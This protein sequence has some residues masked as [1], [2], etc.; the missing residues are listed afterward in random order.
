M[1]MPWGPWLVWGTLYMA[2]EREHGL[3]NGKT[4]MV[5]VLITMLP[6][7]KRWMCCS[8]KVESQLKPL[9]ID[10][11][12]NEKDGEVAVEMTVSRIGK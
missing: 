1:S 11:V 4:L 12:V 2:M 10:M 8:P 6:M 3:L 9:F 7:E 5:G